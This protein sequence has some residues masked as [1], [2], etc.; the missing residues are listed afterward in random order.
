MSLGKLRELVMDREAWRAA[1]HKMAKSWTRLG[2]WT[3]LK[4]N[5]C[6]NVIATVNDV[7]V[8]CPL[9][10]GQ[11]VGKRGGVN[12]EIGIDTCTLL[13]IAVV[14]SLSCVWIFVTPWTVVHQAPLSM[15]F[16]RQE[17]WSGLPFPILG[18]HPNPEIKPRSPSLQA[19][20]LPFEPSGCWHRCKFPFMTCTTL[21]RI[22]TQGYRSRLFATAAGTCLFW[23]HPALYFLFP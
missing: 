10:Y 23:A 9:T 11:W 7:L 21:F 17:S 6:T 8:I 12:W 3:E 14:R 19:D 5:Y 18:D 4:Y 22:T 20:S 13:I 2:D 15:G 1:V 16:S